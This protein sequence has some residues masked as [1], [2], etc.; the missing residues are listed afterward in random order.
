MEP[1]GC[2][3]SLPKGR[4]KPLH[5][6]VPGP[7]RA[8]LAA[9]KIQIRKLSKP[10]RP[11]VII[12][13][14][15]NTLLAAKSEM[16]TPVVC[17]ST[18]SKTESKKITSDTLTR[19]AKKLF[20]DRTAKA[21]AQFKPPLVTASNGE[22][23]PFARPTPIIQALERNVQLLKRAIKVRENSEEEILTNLIEK[24]T[25]AGRE[26]AWEVWNIYKENTNACD[27]EMARKRHYE[28]NWGW[29]HGE[30]SKRPKVEYSHWGLE[31]P[32][33]ETDQE[34]MSWLGTGHEDDAVMQMKDIEVE[35]IPHRT[36][37]TML[38]ELGIAPETLG[39]NEAE[40]TFVEK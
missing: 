23:G 11:P 14:P 36:L 16:S 39:W 5:N 40:E 15:S 25:E 8:T 37:G 22:V 13:G 17:I 12:Q 7:K 1:L 9:Q 18:A 21:A 4:S 29:Q 3:S 31:A 32:Q 30:E 20:K 26:A 35:E 2:S 6:L 34:A 19:Q 38:M 10:F 33:R 24:W 28:D 27:Q